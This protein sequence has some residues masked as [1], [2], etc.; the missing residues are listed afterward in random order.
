MLE[1]PPSPPRPAA[2]G[3]TFGA[4][5]E[6]GV[7]LTKHRLRKSKRSKSLDIVVLFMFY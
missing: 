4:V 2:V 6:R 5:P 1:S 3:E 7:L